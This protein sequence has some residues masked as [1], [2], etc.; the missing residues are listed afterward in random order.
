MHLD[1]SEVTY[2]CYRCQPPGRVFF[3]RRDGSDH[4]ERLD[5]DVCMKPH[6]G[7]P[8]PCPDCGYPGEASIA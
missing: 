3:V 5:D 2:L 4:V 8:G 7:D 6:A 1:T